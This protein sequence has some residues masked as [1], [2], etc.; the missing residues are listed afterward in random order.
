[1]LDADRLH[2][3]FVSTR[4]RLA[5]LPTEY[6]TISNGLLLDHLAQAHHDRPQHD[7][8]VRQ[9]ELCALIDF[10]LVVLADHRFQGL[11]IEK[12]DKPLLDLDQAL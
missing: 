2:N 6:P 10:S 12:P 1:M 3:L 4:R 8:C 9:P 5:V 11:Q 7:R